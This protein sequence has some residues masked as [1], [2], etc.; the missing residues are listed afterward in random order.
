MLIIRVD[1]TTGQVIDVTGTGGAAKTD[2]VPQTEID[3]VYANNP[4]PVGQLIWGRQTAIAAS[5]CL[6]WWQG[7]WI[8][9]C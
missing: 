3:K 7:R 8:K 1:A 5:N 9:V 6:Y 2:P 4:T